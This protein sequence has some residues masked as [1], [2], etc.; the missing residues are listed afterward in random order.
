[1]QTVRMTLNVNEEL[2]AKVTQ[3]HPGV[4][5]TA[6][7]EQGLRALLAQEAAARLAAL[8]G[9]GINASRAKRS[10]WTTK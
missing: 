6:L 3:A 1:M 9:T 5:K 4:T 10:A 7:V 8:G 2:L